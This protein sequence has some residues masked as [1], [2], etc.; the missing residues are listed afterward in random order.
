MSYP[1][2]VDEIV[3]SAFVVALPTFVV[4]VAICRVRIDAWALDAK[5]KSGDE[6]FYFQFIP[7]VDIVMRDWRS[8]ARVRDYAGY[9]FLACLIYF[10]GRAVGLAVA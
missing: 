5:R 6:K 7:P 8:L 2:V 4:T 3:G 1:N 9:A 10:I